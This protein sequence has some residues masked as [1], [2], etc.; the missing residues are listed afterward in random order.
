MKPR[1][2]FLFLFGFLL[3]SCAGSG[4]PSTPTRNALPQGDTA[5]PTAAAPKADAFG[6][7]RLVPGEETGA[8]WMINPAS[9]ARLYVRITSPING[10]GP[11]PV[12]I[13]VPGG[14][15][16]KD[17]TGK[18]DEYSL[19]LAEA[20]FL[21]V[22]FNADGRGQSEGEEDYDGIIHQE[23]LAALVIA[24][25]ELPQA[26]MTKVGIF[27]RS[28]GITMAAGTL[29]RHADLP[30]KFLI[31][32]EGPADRHYTTTGCIP[33]QPNDIPWPPCTDEAFWDSREAVSFIGDMHAAYQRIQSQTDHAQPDNR[34]AVDM[35][36]AAVKG[37][38]PWVRLN[39]YPINQLYDPASPP[40][41]F[42]DDMEKN[43]S[44][45]VVAY[46][47]ELFDL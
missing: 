31:D 26:D 34:H 22:N 9:D 17:L 27:S 24:V 21:V 42:P 13:L 20:G 47:R 29:G 30:V 3:I 5:I 36:N 10:S 25:G 16:N 8:Y 14:I 18:P 41:M 28:Y 2:G 6:D 46:A 23:G 12:V 7:K 44:E 4:G 32:W 38:V 40:A 37:G 15:G 35:V 45:K 33:P 1:H 39:D 43:L 11:Y 19:A